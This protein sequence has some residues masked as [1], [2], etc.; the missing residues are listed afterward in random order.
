MQIALTAS[1]QSAQTAQSTSNTSS[2]SNPTFQATLAAFS[3]PTQGQAVGH[4]HHHHHGSEPAN[5]QQSGTTTANASS[6][7]PASNLAQGIQAYRTAAAMG[8]AITTA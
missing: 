5:K 1:T 7:S 6:T 2:A 4:H 8:T 3:N